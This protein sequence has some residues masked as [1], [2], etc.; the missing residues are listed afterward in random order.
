MKWLNRQ[1]VNMLERER[2]NVVEREGEREMLRLEK[3]RIEYLLYMLQKK[4]RMNKTT[5]ERTK[6]RMNKKEREQE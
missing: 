5:K 4:D 6:E 1:E 3:A 2:G